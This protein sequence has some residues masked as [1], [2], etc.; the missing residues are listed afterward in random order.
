MYRG[1]GPGRGVD[2]EG[3]TLEGTTSLPHRSAGQTFD[4]TKCPERRSGRPRGLLLAEER[5]HVERL[6]GH[7]EA[8][9]GNGRRRN[10][11]LDGGAR[12]PAPA[13]AAEPGRDDRHPDLVAER[14]V[15][16]RAEDDVR[17]LV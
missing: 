14:L 17:V 15:D 1:G 2:S 7:L 6:L 9:A 12:A 4:P 8:A 5:R 3:S 16:H 10:R 13:G 11:S